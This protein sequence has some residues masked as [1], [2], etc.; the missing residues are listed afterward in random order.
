MDGEAVVGCMIYTWGGNSDG[1]VFLVKCFEEGRTID[2]TE[3]VLWGLTMWFLEGRT[4]I[5]SLVSIVLDNTDRGVSLLWKEAEG[6]ADADS[7]VGWKNLD[8]CSRLESVLNMKYTS[9][10]LKVYF[11]LQDL[12]A[13]CPAWWVS[14]TGAANYEFPAYLVHNGKLPAPRVLFLFKQLRSM[15]RCIGIYRSNCSCKW[16]T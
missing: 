3:R 2:E 14:S 1:W 6:A 15:L 4:L 11:S 12:D 8:L 9:I 10:L 13:C 16:Y 7:L 5:K